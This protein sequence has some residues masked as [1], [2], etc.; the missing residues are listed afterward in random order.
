MHWFLVRNEC[1]FHFFLSVWR[2]VR[3]SNLLFLFFSGKSWS[4]LNAKKTF[5]LW[6]SRMGSLLETWRWGCTSFNAKLASNFQSSYGLSFYFLT[7]SSFRRA[8][9][10]NLIERG[11]TIFHYSSSSLRKDL[12]DHCEELFA[13]NVSF[14][15]ISST[16]K[17][18]TARFRL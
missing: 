13:V 15:I 2:V 4:S 18:I 1:P 5:F 10:Y 11:M 12:T 3:K 16:E 9:H 17:P 14:Q 8:F 7:F 6:R